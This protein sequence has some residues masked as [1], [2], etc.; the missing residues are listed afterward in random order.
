MEPSWDIKWP[1]QGFCQAKSNRKKPSCH[2]SNAMENTHRNPGFLPSFDGG[3]SSAML[4]YWSFCWRTL[5]VSSFCNWVVAP[6]IPSMIYFNRKKVCARWRFVMTWSV[7]DR[8]IMFILH[9]RCGTVN[10]HPV[11]NLINQKSSSRG[12]IDQNHVD[13]KIL[14]GKGLQYEDS[15]SIAFVWPVYLL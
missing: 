8:F 9:G 3:F 4:V 15:T 10:I 14:G 1:K 12:G 7:P 13:K 2:F 6:Y 11:L 5:E